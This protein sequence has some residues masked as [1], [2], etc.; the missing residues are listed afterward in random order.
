M[1]K[2]VLLLTLCAVFASCYLARGTNRIRPSLY[3]DSVVV[4][5]WGDSISRI[6]FAGSRAVAYILHQPQGSELI[7]S[8]IAGKIPRYV[9][10]IE[11]YFYIIL[12]ALMMSQVNYDLRPYEPKGE[13][14]PYVAFEVKY[15]KERCYIL[16]GLSTET[17]AVWH[18]GQLK[19]YQTRSN[20]F[21]VEYLLRLMP[22]D[23]YLQTLSKYNNDEVR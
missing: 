8:K 13:F 16:F 5:L 22:Q 9:T 10:K 19:R 23:E 3:P 6:L 21:L 17:W 14:A 11:P 18:N 2:L 7:Q 20:K 15:K 12:K 4:K 1:R